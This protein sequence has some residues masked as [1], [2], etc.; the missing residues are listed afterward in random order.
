MSTPPKARA[1]AAA[2]SRVPALPAHAAVFL[3]IDGT[4]VGHEERP[5]DVRIDVELSVLLENVARASSGALALISG[6]SI[7]D[8]DALFAPARFALAG[9]HGAERRSAD[10][11]LHLHQPLASCLGRCGKELRRFVAA[12]PGLLLEEKGASLALHFRGDP[13]LGSAVEREARRVM[14]LFG[15]DFELL[16]GKYVFELKQSGRDKRMAIAEFM[17]EHP[18]RG[19]VPVF[20]G[21]DLTDEIGFDLVNRTGGCSVKVGPGATCAPWRLA[22]ERAVRAWLASAAALALGPDGQDA[23]RAGADE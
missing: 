22:D 21:D 12:R 20:V 4:L 13:S 18:F 3:D 1:Q 2:P 15:G 7:A 16:A 17:E 10:G 19:R 9:Q 11:V 8:I 23:R 6:R 14:G 5:C